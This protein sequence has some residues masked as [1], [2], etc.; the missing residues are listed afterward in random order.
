[1]SNII[2][3]KKVALFLE[4]VE[5]KIQQEIDILLPEA[6]GEVYRKV[7]EITYNEEIIKHDSSGSA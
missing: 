2:K 6:I 7:F 5:T 4:T 3:D 1:M